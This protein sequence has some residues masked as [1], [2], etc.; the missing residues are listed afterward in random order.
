MTQPQDD[1]LPLCSEEIRDAFKRQ[2]QRYRL[3]VPQIL[4]IILSLALVILAGISG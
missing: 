2:Q 3:S 4:G 1:A